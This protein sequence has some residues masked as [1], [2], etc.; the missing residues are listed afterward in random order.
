M[1]QL[2]VKYFLSLKLNLFFSITH[3][4][5]QKKVYYQGVALKFK[6]DPNV[7]YLGL[8]VTVQLN[9]DCI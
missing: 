7:T 4:N 3:E 5:F 1:A 8:S 9:I 2:S 6:I